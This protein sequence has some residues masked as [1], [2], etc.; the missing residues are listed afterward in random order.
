[1]LADNCQMVPFITLRSALS[2]E[3]LCP[4]TVIQEDELKPVV[5]SNKKREYRSESFMNTVVPR[6]LDRVAHH[7]SYVDSDR[8]VHG[9]EA[10]IK[11]ISNS[12][13]HET[14]PS[15]ALGPHNE[16]IHQE[17]TGTDDEE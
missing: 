11:P 5:E 1:M 15:P 13:Q 6:Q 4:L 2:P 9:T 7:S 17:E 14:P 12:R 16:C 8:Q 3:L 10:T